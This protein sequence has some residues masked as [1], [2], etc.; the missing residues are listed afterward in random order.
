[1]ITTVNL[2]TY[3]LLYVLPLG[4][5]QS[6]KVPPLISSLSCWRGK[7]SNPTD[8]HHQPRNEKQTLY[9]LAC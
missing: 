3:F 5:F 6:H 8:A 9:L 1:M 2:R 4:R 7:R